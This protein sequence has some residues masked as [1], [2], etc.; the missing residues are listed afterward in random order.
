MILAYHICLSKLWNEI[1]VLALKAITQWPWSLGKI[2]QQESRLQLILYPC[3]LEEEISYRIIWFPSFPSYFLVFL[4]LSTIRVDIFILTFFGF[5]VNNWYLYLHS[6]CFGTKTTILSLNVQVFM[7]LF[8]G[9]LSLDIIWS[10]CH[11]SALWD[12]V[13]CILPPH[14]SWLLHHMWASLS[15]RASHYSCSWLCFLFDPC[16]I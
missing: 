4:S 16:W 7:L 9:M 11:W 6:H 5:S 15:N 1:F 12:C 2:L 13:F 10:L 3:N 14:F 8:R